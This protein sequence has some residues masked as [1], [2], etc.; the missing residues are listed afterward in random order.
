[1]INDKRIKLAF[2]MFDEDAN[3][4]VEI[5]EFKMAMSGLNISHYEWVGI[6]AEID[7]DGDGR[8]SLEEFT[9]MLRNIK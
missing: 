4:F 9:A 1:M 3:G 2:N 5:E 6:I 7:I 8:I